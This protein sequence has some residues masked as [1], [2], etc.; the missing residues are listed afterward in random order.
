PSQLSRYRSGVIDVLRQ[1]EDVPENFAGWAGP[2]AS[3]EDRDPASILN[4]LTFRSLDWESFYEGEA[5]VSVPSG[6]LILVV[7]YETAG[8]AGAYQVLRP[9]DDTDPVSLLD[10]FLRA[11]GIDESKVLSTEFD[12]KRRPASWERS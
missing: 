2:F 8:R 1:L 7:E 3:L 4:T 5:L 11:S 12:G 6:R 9:M 10:E